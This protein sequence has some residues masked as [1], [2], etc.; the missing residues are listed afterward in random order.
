MWFNPAVTTNVSLSVSVRTWLTSVNAEASS[1][2]AGNDLACMC[3]TIVKPTGRVFAGAGLDAL[4]TNLPTSIFALSMSTL[5]GPA[6]APDELRSHPV[7]PDALA[8]SVNVPN[9]DA[10]VS[11]S[12][13]SLM[14]S[15]CRPD[16]WPEGELKLCVNWPP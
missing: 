2:P 4:L 1:V 5:S 12:N 3:W 13:F 7:E 8:E 10:A 6:I 14:F 9:P 16:A 11:E 15:P